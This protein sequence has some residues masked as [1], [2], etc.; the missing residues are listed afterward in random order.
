[1][2]SEPPGRRYLRRAITIPLVLTGFL[3]VTAALPA[4]VLIA[5]L[6]DLLRGGG[7]AFS[8]VRVALFA[9][10]FLATETVGLGL[11]GLAWLTSRGSALPW[12]CRCCKRWHGDV[13]KPRAA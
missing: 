6:V 9:F 11:L 2:P 10:T 4:L 7:K 8:S 13:T 1:M 12:R 5:L 3:A